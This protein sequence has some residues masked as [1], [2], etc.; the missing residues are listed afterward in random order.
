M[1]ALTT[2]PI[3]IVASHVRYALPQED[4]VPIET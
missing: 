3:D 4:E 2:G 1:L